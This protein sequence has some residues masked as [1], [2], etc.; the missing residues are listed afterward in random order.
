MGILVE[1]QVFWLEPDENPYGGE[2]EDEHADACPHSYDLLSGVHP[3]AEQ[4]RCQESLDN[5]QCQNEKNPRGAVIASMMLVLGS[6]VA[7]I[8]FYA[9]AIVSTSCLTV[10]IRG[11][12]PT[13]VHHST[14]D[15]LRVTG[16]GSM[17]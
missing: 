17:L 10:H 11:S 14:H 2:H 15:S 1:G 9:A 8:C 13:G 6:F 12:P 4:H 3:R 5:Q 7:C 16:E